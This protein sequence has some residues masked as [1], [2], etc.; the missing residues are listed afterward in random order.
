MIVLLVTD[1]LGQF[2]TVI[3]VPPNVAPGSI[4]SDTQLNV[5]D[6]GVLP[7]FFD[8]GTLDGFSTNVEVNILGGAVGKD[9]DA[10]PGSAVN[11]SGGSVDWSFNA[12]GGSA[13][14]ISGGTIGDDFSAKSGSAVTIS[15]GE[16]RSNGVPIDGLE[17]EGDTVSFNVPSYSFL[18]GT[19]A[20]GTPFA[21]SR[22]DRASRDSFASDVLTLETATLPPVGPALIT[23]STDRVPFGIRQGQRLRVDSGG[24]VP[25][26]FNAGRGSTV[27]VEVGGRVGRNFEAVDAQVNI[28][29]G[30]VGALFDAFSGSTVTISGGSVGVLFD[31][32]SGSTVNI[33]GGS[34]GGRFTAYTG[35]TVRISG[36]AFGEVFKADS[37]SAVTIS[38]GEFFVNGVPVGGLESEGDTVSLDVPVGALLTGTLADGTP[39]AFF[40]GSST[41]DDAI[42]R[43]VLTLEAAPLPPVGPALITASTDAVPLGIRQGQTLRVDFG[44]VVADNFNAGPG[45]TVN[46]EPGGRVGRNFEAIGAE[47]NVFGGSVGGLFDMFSGSRVAITGGLFSDARAIGSTVDISGGS[48]FSFVAMDGNT[49]NISGGSFALKYIAG[50]GSTV[51]FSGGSVGN[52]FEARPESTVIISGGSLG[53]RFRAWADSE[54]DLIGREFFL[55]GLPIEELVN[56]GDSLVLETREGRRLTGTL[57]DGNLFDFVLNGSSVVPGDYFHPSAILRL[58]LGVPEPSTLTLALGA[59]GMAVVGFLQRGKI[60]R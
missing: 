42:A 11:I 39:L 1:A 53:D 14:T 5:S 37:N 52:R 47:V 48:F 32:F 12:N 19:L 6:G 35:S 13:V 15:G 29:G 3:N 8:A 60:F 16:F 40:H 10:A 58:T 34:V 43:G 20:D 27:V 51:D 2:T 33:S 50:R 46:V 9:F 28:S 41:S 59:I 49:A 44:G 26:S 54:V 57:L 22:L 56:P 30:S 55:D 31:A 36:G 24:V 38:G 17:N 23:A 21:F 45:S 18:S 4:S 25:D 7:D